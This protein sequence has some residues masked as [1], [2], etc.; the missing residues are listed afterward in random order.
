VLP[1]RLGV[2]PLVVLLEEHMAIVIIS[3]I[4]TAIKYCRKAAHPSV[5][6]KLTRATLLINR[7]G[8][9]AAV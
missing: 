7:N 4:S 1:G 5:V 8:N 2:R 3:L 6:P 9:D